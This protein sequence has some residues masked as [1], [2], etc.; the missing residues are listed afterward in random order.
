MKRNT[1][2]TPS[3]VTS[4]S[5]RDRAVGVAV[6][7]ATTPVASIGDVAPALAEDRW[8]KGTPVRPGLGT[9]LYV[10]EFRATWRP[11]CRRNISR[12]TNLPRQ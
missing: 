4:Y 3:H 1:S 5:S 10:V 7:A 9:N 8:I 11:A 2:S 12:L 6:T